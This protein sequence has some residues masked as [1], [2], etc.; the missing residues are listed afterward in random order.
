MTLVILFV[1]GAIIGSFLNVLALR[2]RSGISIGGRSQCGS[3]SKVLP[4][5]ELIPVVSFLAL[6]GR[7][8]ACRAKISWRYPA[9]EILT[10]I[11]FATVYEPGSPW[12]V[13]G[14]FLAIFSL[15]VVIVIY[16][17]RHKV[18]PNSLA[19]AATFLALILSLG[20]QNSWLDWFAGPILF[21]FFAVIWLLS[22]GRAMGFGDAKLALSMGLMLG[23]AGGFSAVI[24]AFWTGAL[25]GLALI[26][27]GMLSPLLR[28][29]KR[30]TMKSEVPFAPFLV[31]GA[32]L[33]L[34]FKLDLL[35]VSFFH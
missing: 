5:Y 1:C 23:A 16:D 14:L 4:W 13:N 27:A 8:S 22:R 15:Y 21:V 7:C 25:Y 29:G 30:I 11:I 34:I 9:G 32:W 6:R 31:L 3:C 24:L 19:Y 33:A 12:W 18:I 2:F 20:G 35:H 17:A 28:S 26:V 10:G